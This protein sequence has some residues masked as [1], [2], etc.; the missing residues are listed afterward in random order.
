MGTGSRDMHILVMLWTTE[1]C[2]AAAD[3]ILSGVV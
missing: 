2:A 1:V 3:P